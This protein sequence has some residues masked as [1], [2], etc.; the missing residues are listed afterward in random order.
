MIKPSSLSQET[1]MTSSSGS[2][3]DHLREPQD[4]ARHS[5]A[6]LNLMVEGMGGADAVSEGVVVLGQANVGP[7]QP[8]AQWPKVQPVSEPL[9]RAAEQALAIRSAVQV[10]GAS[11]IWAVPLISDGDLFGV[12]A[13][14]FKQATIPARAT[15]WM[16]WGQGWLM[17]NAMRGLQT[18]STLQE[19]LMFLVDTIML[20]M[21]GDDLR[22]SVQAV[23][24]EVAH[25]L[26]AERISMGLAEHGGNAKLWSISHAGDFSGRLSLTRG[27]EAAMDEA[28]DQANVIDFSRQDD[29]NVEGQMLITRAHKDYL[30]MSGSGVVLSI[31]H[32]VDSKMSMAF[33]FEWADELA[34]QNQRHLAMGLVPVMAK[35]FTERR[36]AQVSW[37]RRLLSDVR[38]AAAWL[39][40]PR[41]AWF[42]VLALLVLTALVV[43]SVVRM[44][45]EVSADARLEGAVV[46][47][48][49][50]PFDGFVA[51]SLLRAGQ[52]VSKGGVLAVL[53]DRDLK[54]EVERWNSEQAQ[55]RNQFQDA[56][57]QKNLAQVQI[58]LAQGRQA[59]AQRA[60][61]ESNLSRSKVS[62][63]MAGIIV[64]GDLSQQLGAPVQK[65]QLLFEVAPLNDYR[66]VLQVDERDID[67]L[68]VGQEGRLM[69]TALSG[70]EM[71]L[72]ITQ[73]S[74]VTEVVEG[75]NRF[76][77]EASLA[78]GEEL[79]RPGMKGIARLDT[80][81]ERVLWVWLRGL[82]EWSRLTLW[83]WWGL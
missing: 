46:R 44:P 69:L 48:I 61:S 29:L 17:A 73:I 40:G 23:L 76:R 30:Q 37:W 1:K 4:V 8:Q 79:L 5:V 9:A 62:S 35:V 19:E 53:D 58:N 20:A 59:Q 16:R 77:V 65:G 55:Y 78:S 6:W 83:K 42:K 72:K 67:L 3:W 66:V 54:L 18:Q 80:G 57:A 60:L 33:V 14:R 51:Q 13:V 36:L 41:H 32:A 45:L 82:A 25:R 38:D 50:A 10:A 75:S 27:L 7:Y 39:V 34:A 68:S 11:C 63:P 12:V 74:P 70:Q 26:K 24:I 28:L 22:M 43:M 31:P 47:Q 15:A 81:E 71:S 49:H 64:S 52:E 56:Q 2:D 21:S